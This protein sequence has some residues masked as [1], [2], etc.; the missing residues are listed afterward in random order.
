ML[1]NRKQ[2]CTLLA[3]ASLIAVHIFLIFDLMFVTKLFY[4]LLRLK[5]E[6]TL[7]LW[8]AL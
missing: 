3:T 5:T 6:H 8:N 4:C 2:S 7:R 1:Q